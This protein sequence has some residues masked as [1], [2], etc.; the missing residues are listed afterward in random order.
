MKKPS[1][2]RDRLSMRAMSAE[3]FLGMAAVAS[4]TMSAS[5]SIG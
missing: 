1:E 3:P 5:T 4:T 2:P